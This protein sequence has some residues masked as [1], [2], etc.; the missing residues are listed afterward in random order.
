MKKCSRCK[1]N[2]PDSSFRLRANKRNLQ[3]LCRRCEKDSWKRYMA[4]H[5]LCRLVYNLRRHHKGDLTTTQLKTIPR[6]ICYLCGTA[7]VS[8]DLIELDHVIP[9]SKGGRTT[10]ANL[11]WAH[12]ACNRIKHD[13]TLQELRE[14]LRRILDHLDKAE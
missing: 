5:P 12:R 8:G 4:T 13:C 1:K 11:K 2:L 6:D 7:F 9:L 14:L 3:S 10:L